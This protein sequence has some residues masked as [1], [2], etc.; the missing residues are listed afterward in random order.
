MALAAA[1][2]ASA[3]APMLPSPVPATHDGELETTRGI[4]SVIELRSPTAPVSTA[5][6]VEGPS[7]ADAN[8]LAVAVERVM[9]R[10]LP[11]L[12]WKIMA[13]LDLNKRS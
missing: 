13:E 2:A 9:K 12:I 11:N 6:Q 1:A 10:E 8:K 7:P 5:Y 3:P 4:A